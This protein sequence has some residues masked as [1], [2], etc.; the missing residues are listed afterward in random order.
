MFTTARFVRLNRVLMG[1]MPTHSYIFTGRSPCPPYTSLALRIEAYI[2]QSV[3]TSQGITSNNASGHGSRDCKRARPRLHLP[4]LL[5]HAVS[6]ETRELLVN[7]RQRFSGGAAP[8][9]CFRIRH[10]S[11]SFVSKTHIRARTRA[12]EAGNNSRLRPPARP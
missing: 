5:A 11:A 6:L 4:A 10:K 3:Q 2:P 1:V 8:S 12:Q 9:S 7:L